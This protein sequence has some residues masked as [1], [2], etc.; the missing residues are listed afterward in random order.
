MKNILFQ[1]INDNYIY[2]I[3]ILYIWNILF[4][5]G[6]E[7]QSERFSPKTKIQGAPLNPGKT[8]GKPPHEQFS[9]ERILSIVIDNARNRLW[10]TKN[11]QYN[12][13]I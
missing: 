5:R 11:K 6:S 13:L 1:S 3:Y 7:I 4:K 2:H 8:N 9:Q 10:T 12:S